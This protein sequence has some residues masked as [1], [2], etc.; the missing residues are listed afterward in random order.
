MADPVLTGSAG[1][2]ASTRPAD[3]SGDAPP[4]RLDPATR[5]LATALL[6]H[7]EW[8]ELRRLAA[9]GRHGLLEALDR[10]VCAVDDLLSDQVNAIL[11]HPRF[12]RLEASW[13]SLAYLVARLERT[14]R[15]KLRVLSTRWAEVERD[16]DRAVEFDQSQ[17][18]RKIYSDEFGM[19]GGEPYGLLIGDYF[20]QHRPPKR[21]GVDD[22]ATLR[23]LSGIAA[24]AFA[25]LIVGAAPGLLGVDSFRDLSPS[26]DL[27]GLF[28]QREYNRWQALQDQEDTRFLGVV[29]PPVLLREPYAELPR[30]DGFRF[31]EDVTSRDTNGYLWGNPAYAFASVV[32]RAFDDTG[33][34]ADI[35]GTRAEDLRG[36][37]V[38]DLPAPSF[39]T[40][41]H[42]VA[43]IAPLQISL[44]DQQ[45]RA[46]SDLGFISLVASPYTPYA[47]FYGNQS[48][49]RPRRYDSAV[50]STN[51][52]MSAMLHYMLC[53]SRFAHYVKVLGRDM[54]GSFITPEECERRLQEWLAGYT[55]APTGLESDATLL[56]SYPLS[57]GEVQVR[58][59]PARPGSYHCMIYLRPHYQL[60]EVVSTFRL[61]TELAPGVST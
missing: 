20:V 25:P 32:M 35:R 23:G 27:G 11:H 30:R 60:D 13:R 16:L 47:I 24:A 57:Q 41:R 18:F 36:G 1:V 53:V 6:E 22:V 52:R 51:A 9:E 55:M 21:G 48:L 58:E 46:L 61:T 26:L 37:L 59:M 56:A 40:D 2:H 10:R 49:L 3:V 7:F 12:Q 31:R 28:R 43:Q 38:A 39:G 14:D 29:A 4:P 44:S 45:E 42:G 50:A 33:W 5:W 15:V 34:F 8:S 19:P 54:V 17:L